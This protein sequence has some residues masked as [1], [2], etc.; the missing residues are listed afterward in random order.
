MDMMANFLYYPPKSLATIDSMEF[1]QF[2]NLP[3]GQSVIIAILCYSSYIKNQSS[4]DPFRSI[5]Y[6]CYMDAEERIGM[7]V[8]EEF[9]RF[10]RAN[11][12]R[13]KHGTYDKLED[14]GLIAPGTPVSGDHI[15]IGKTAPISSDSEELGQRTKFHTKRDVSKPMR[16]T[17]NGIIDQ[18]MITTNQE[19]LKF[20]KV[21]VRSTRAPQIEDK[22]PSWH[23]QKGTIGIM[24]RH[25]DMSF[26]SEGIA[27]D[28][29]INPHAILSRMT[30]A[31]LIECQLSKVSALSGHEGDA[32]L[33]KYKTTLT[34]KTPSPFSCSELTGFS[35]GT[36][37]DAISRSLR[38]H[39]YQ[40]RGFEIMYNGHTGKNSKPKSSSDQ[41]TS[42]A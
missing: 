16:S 40:S 23:G 38:E 30:V 17:E 31:H 2:H 10:M 8:V 9:E 20:V 18:V 14:D 21:R 29:I 5:F 28:L 6:R 13:L 22:F 24:Y 1:L 4:I 33:F 25:E 7:Q 26:M 19:G 32:T 41:P 27:S 34:P 3:A 37:V 12:L 36:T 35:D 15:I 42:N 39:D 11:T